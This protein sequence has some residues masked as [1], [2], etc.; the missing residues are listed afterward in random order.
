MS[1]LSDLY[2]PTFWADNYGITDFDTFKEA[3]ERYL[4][5][6][7]PF[8]NLGTNSTSLLQGYEFPWSAPGLLFQ[9]GLTKDE[10]TGEAAA[11]GR[12]LLN[13]AQQGLI[14]NEQ[15]TGLG[16]LVI[17][18]CFQVT[19]EMA[20]GGKTIENVIGVE[21]AGGTASGAAGA[22]KTAWEIASG[23]LARLPYLVTMQQY[24]AVDIGSTSG[25]IY[26]LSSTG[27][28]GIT[29]VSLATRGAC[30]LVQWN[31]AT[32]NRSS[33]GRLYFGPLSEND[34]NSDGATVNTTS[35]TNIGTAFTNFRNSLSSSGYN[36]VVLSR[37][38]S[39]S[40]P[41]TQHSVETQLATQR[42]RI[43]V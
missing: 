7:L 25:A 19:I 16:M 3:C 38:L 14:Q 13:L 43:R 8:G 30:A 12:T 1:G 17:P 42:R 36:L 15:G 4:P 6:V 28:G 24:H 37:V 40:F 10:Y 22:V 29:A 39:D 41:V 33:R 27:V 26:D 2:G 32:R 5:D 34:V 11:S 35:K 23:P 20:C 18:S 31:G 9:Q 21:N